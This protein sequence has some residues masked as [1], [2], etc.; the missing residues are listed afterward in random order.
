MFQCGTI[1]KTLQYNDNTVWF[2][3]LLLVDI[4]NTS[5][6]LRTTVVKNFQ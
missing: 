4:I 1:I 6:D 5:L 3:T 2:L